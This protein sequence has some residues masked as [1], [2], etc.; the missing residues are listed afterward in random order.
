MANY[1]D[2][3]IDELLTEFPEY[4]KLAT[5]TPSSAPS[6]APSSLVQVSAAQPET[7]QKVQTTSKSKRRPMKDVESRVDKCEKT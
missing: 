6:S 7:S 5:Q 3:M 1:V 2:P 4:L